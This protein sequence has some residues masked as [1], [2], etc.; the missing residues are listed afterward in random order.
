MFGLFKKKSEVDKLNDKY[1]V[2]LKE[3]HD[4]STSNRKLSD[5]KTAEA[6]KVLKQIE[7]LEKKN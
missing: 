6:N 4:L 2:P 3:A 1:K 5:V 7:Q